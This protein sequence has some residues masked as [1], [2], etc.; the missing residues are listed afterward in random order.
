MILRKVNAKS[1][2]FSKLAVYCN[3]SAVGLGNVLDNRQP[4]TGAAHGAAAGLV[5]AVKPFKKPWQMLF[6]DANSLILDL[7]LNL[8]IVLVGR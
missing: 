8:G 5:Y 2:A 1:A 7:N 3:M 6:C 4:Q